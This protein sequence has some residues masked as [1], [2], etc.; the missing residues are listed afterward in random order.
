M[1]P[2]LLWLGRRANQTNDFHPA[3]QLSFYLAVLNGLS[4]VFFIVVS[5]F[6]QYTDIHRTSHA[7]VEQMTG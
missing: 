4:I 3:A 7:T 2:L 1:A 5:L 6:A